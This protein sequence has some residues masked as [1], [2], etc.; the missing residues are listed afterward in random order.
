M[1]GTYLQNANRRWA[2]T[3]ATPHL[4]LHG[5][6]IAVWLASTVASVGLH[7]GV[8]GMLTGGLAAVIWVFTAQGF[9]SGFAHRNLGLCNIVTATR[10][11]LVA[12]LFGGLSAGS[13]GWASV[14]LAG[15]A[16]ALDGLD[17]WLAR[18]QNMCTAFGARFDMEVDSAL[19]AVLALLLL[20]AGKAG[21]EILVLGFAR[22]VFLFAILLRPSLG[23]TLP[24]SFRRKAVCVL[25]IAT[26]IVLILPVVPD[27]RILSVVAALALVWS[28]AV[29]ILWLER[30]R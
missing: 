28:F 16:F 30:N 2:V 1:I 25:Q 15:I 29:D 22:Y 27:L 26:L 17:G 12:V 3:P 6:M 5:L 23:A 14:L 19:A 4:K 11:G 20:T 8:G 18:R 24:H 13:I 10:A 9:R 7:G 21:P